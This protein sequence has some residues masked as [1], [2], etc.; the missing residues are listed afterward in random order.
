MLH[1][2]GGGCMKHVLPL[3]EEDQ[4]ERWGD[5]LIVIFT[6]GASSNKGEPHAFLYFTFHGFDHR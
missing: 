6:H 3:W 2:R 5:K 4:S 1:T